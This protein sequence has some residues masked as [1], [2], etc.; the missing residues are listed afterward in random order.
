LKEDGEFMEYTDCRNPVL[1]PE[2]HIPDPEAHVMPDGRVYVYGSY[3]KEQFFYCSKE[4]RVV[5]SANMIDWTDHGVSF[6][7]EDAPWVTNANTT[8]YPGGIGTFEPTQFMKRTMPGFVGRGERKGPPPNFRRMEALL[9]APDAIHRNGKYFLYYCTSNSHEGVAVSDKPEGPFIDVGQLPCGGIDPA[10]FIDDDG[11]AYYYW[12]QFYAKG[13]KL[14]PNMVQIEEGSVV[15]N[16][17]TEEEHYF[18]EGSSMRKRGD[19][20]YFVYA[21]MRRGKPTSLGYAMGKSPLG[22]F[23]HKGIIIDN[24]GCDPSSWNNHG[25]IE[26]VNGQWYVFYHRS[27]RNSQK[28]RRLCV[29]PI[30][31]NEDGTINEAK[32]TSQGA[33][34]P[35][36][37]GE[38]I[39]AYRACGLTGN[40]FIAPVEGVETLTS[41]RDGDTAVYRYVEWRSP[42]VSVTA[43]AS[44]SGTVEIFTDGRVAG[45]IKIENGDVVFSEL[46]AENGKHEILLKF[47]DAQG[48]T[49]VDFIFQ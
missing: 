38:K 15:E 11:Q 41:I 26:E 10:V 42:P 25:S 2:I 8:K 19:T 23:E 21:C 43:K 49:L 20:Y 30:T 29:E 44:G 17:V 14:K 9:F 27:S 12:G 31:F 45:K 24:D 47:T 1:P 6:S 39:E 46:N 40:C 33:G 3:D 16:L 36:G 4:Y 48:L 22:P 34:R 7:I 28:M 18:H 37:L 32:M 35:F 5:S 13:A